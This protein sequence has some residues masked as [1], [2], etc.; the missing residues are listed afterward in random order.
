MT[1]KFL[2]KILSHKK[3]ITIMSSVCHYICSLSSY[4]MQC[5]R[6]FI[7]GELQQSNYRSAAT[8][9]RIAE[10][11]YNRCRSEGLIDD[12]PVIVTVESGVTDGNV[13]VADERGSFKCERKTFD[14]KKKSVV[15]GM[16]AVHTTVRTVVTEC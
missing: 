6:I 8:P 4:T 12:S 16:I 9:K 13:F 11:W 10:L 15:T 14:R 5:Y 1:V 2:Y 7:N 3:M